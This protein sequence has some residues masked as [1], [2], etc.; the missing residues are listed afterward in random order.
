ME[1]MSTDE[2]DGVFDR[3]DGWY[4]RRRGGSAGASSPI[5][6]PS[7]AAPASIEPAPVLAERS[8]DTTPVRPSAGP[9]RPTP[10]LDER[11]LA[12][13]ALALAERAG[14]AGRRLVSEA[15]KRRR[16]RH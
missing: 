10:A 14:R 13:R 7:Q 5:G 16:E 2:A 6:T 3:L 11:P 8:G 9:A 1:L 15:A 12:E 4:E